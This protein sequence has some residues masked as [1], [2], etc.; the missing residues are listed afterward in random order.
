MEE[1]VIGKRKYVDDDAMVTELD[2]NTVVYGIPD[3][4]TNP[5]TNTLEEIA[6]IFTTEF[7][8]YCPKCGKQNAPG[9]QV[10]VL[11]SGIFIYPCKQCN[12]FAWSIKRKKNDEMKH[13][14]RN[15]IDDF[16]G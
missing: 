1:I 10:T 8:T 15:N 9:L 7:P 3:Y 5:I 6:T 12:Q 11:K 4:V 14:K 2:E 16:M 13:E